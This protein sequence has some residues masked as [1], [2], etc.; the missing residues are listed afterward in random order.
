MVGKNPKGHTVGRTGRGFRRK[1]AI[2]RK[3]CEARNDPCA[4]CHGKYGPIRYDLS[5]RDPMGWQLDHEVFFSEMPPGDPR[6][7]DQRYWRS[8]HARCNQ[9]R[10]A[11]PEYRVERK[12]ARPAGW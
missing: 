3:R 7:M 8:S 10:G 11:R 9:R 12:P 4:I 6:R 5:D 2:F 1:R